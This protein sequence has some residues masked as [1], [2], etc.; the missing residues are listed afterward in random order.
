MKVTILDDYTDTVRTLDCFK[1]LAGHEVRIWTDHLQ[2]AG[3]LAARLTGTQALV[4]IR[5]R[6]RIEAPMLESVP[7][8]K[9]ISQRGAYPHIDVAACTRL[10]IAVASNLHGGGPSHA[11]VELTWALILAAMRRLPQ[12]VEAMKAGLWQTAVG[13]GVRGKTLGIYGYGK[14]GGA[15]A[16]IGKAFGMNVLVWARD[17]SRERAARDGYATASGKAAFFET[18]DVVSL[19]MR[20]LD[21]TRG[22]VT[23]QD[24]ARMKTD[25]LIVNTS[26]AGLI[27]PGALEDALR[28][29][30]PGMAALDVFEQ[31]PV[32]APDYP[33]LTLDNAIC[34]PHIG[35]VTLDDYELQFGDIFDQIN[36]FAEGKP[37]HIV[38]PEVLN[39]KP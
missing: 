21:A 36:A 13:R 19:H 5:E 4:C 23:A 15:V 8:L 29:G 9:L 38:N 16:A 27:A 31:E 24:L 18:S 12:Q 2:E 39:R 25:A 35:Y 34:T 7:G 6:T 10:G 33:L 14:I 17:E 37:I 1:K 28:K 26:R 22:I 11:T 32:Y 30:R 20:L 3:A